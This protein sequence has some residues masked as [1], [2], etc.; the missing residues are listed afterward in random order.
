MPDSHIESKRLVREHG[1]KILTEIHQSDYLGEGACRGVVGDWIQSYLNAHRFGEKGFLENFR[2]RAGNLG[3]S[4][5][6][7]SQLIQDEFGKSDPFVD[8]PKVGKPE[9]IVQAVLTGLDKMVSMVVMNHA[10]G[11]IVASM[12]H[13]LSEIAMMLPKLLPETG[14]YYVGMC[15][16]FKHALG[17]YCSPALYQFID[18]NSCEFELRGDNALRTRQKFQAFLVDYIATFYPEE[19]GAPIIIF[20]YPLRKV[21]VG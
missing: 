11:R 19:I 10:K 8:V 15:G 3:G 18:A 9:E 2:S 6:S 4:G 7:Q 12:D 20:F 21:K 5:A 1:V 16:K 13:T 14:F 17:V